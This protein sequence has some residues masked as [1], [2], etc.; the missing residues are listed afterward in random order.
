VKNNIFHEIHV[1][2]V[3]A[4]NITNL[5]FIAGEQRGGKS[6]NYQRLRKIFTVPVWLSRLPSDEIGQI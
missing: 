2:K 5:V 3:E 6:C 4:Q 1:L